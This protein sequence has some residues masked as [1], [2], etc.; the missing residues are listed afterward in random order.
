VPGV[1]V[2]AATPGISF[3]AGPVVVAI[4]VAVWSC[5]VAGVA[6]AA[7]DSRGAGLP[8]FASARALPRVDVPSA[9]NVAS[10]ARVTVA[11]PAATFAGG[12]VGGYVV[13]VT[14]AT[15]GIPRAAAGGC[16]GRL[17]ATTC[18]EPA[19]P[20]GLWRYTV[21]SVHGDAWESEPSAP[22]ATVT[23]DT[24]GPTV[25]AIAAGDGDGKI[26]KNDFLRLTFN[27]PLDPASVPQS[28]AFSVTNVNGSETMTVTGVTEGAVPTGT[29]GSAW[30]NQTTVW[31]ASTALSA[32]NTVLTVTV[33]QPSAIW[34][35]AGAPPGIVQFVPAHTL[36]DVAGNGSGGLRAQSVQLF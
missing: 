20:D 28:T 26:E 7:W 21:A 16:A 10:G 1:A 33:T 34:S 18:V 14:D 25:V 19:A 9:S 12:P 8:A 31:T 5:L 35:G 13:H 27:E 24:T 15:S 30:R 22:S 4:C 11:W 32:G 36:K 23:V 2:T 29:G 6:H 3:R 17:A